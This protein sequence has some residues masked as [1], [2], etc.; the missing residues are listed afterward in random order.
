M[1]NKVDAVDASMIIQRLVA[2]CKVT[3][4]DIKD[5]DKYSADTLSSIAQ[6]VFSVDVDIPEIIEEIEKKAGVTK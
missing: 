2:V 3:P 6:R 4:E 1:V 5:C